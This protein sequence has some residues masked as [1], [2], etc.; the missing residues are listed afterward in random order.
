MATAA[1]STELAVLLVDARNGLLTQTLRHSHIVSLLGIRHVVLA[2][3]KMD[4]VD[5]DRRIFDQIADSY[6]KLADQ[7]GLADVMC[8]PISAL[9][10]DN[11]TSQSATMPWYAGPTLLG[12]LETANLG[13]REAKPFRM[14]VQWVNRPHQDFRGYCGTVASGLV[15]SR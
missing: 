9:R 15:T 6:R 1:S 13:D 7:I 11:V 14:P 8:I 2:V 10:G 12:H 5:W 4:V 3:N